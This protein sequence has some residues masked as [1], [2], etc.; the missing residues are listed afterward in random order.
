MTSHEQKFEL[1]QKGLT[2][3]EIARAL[4]ISISAVNTWRRTKGLPLNTVP[5]SA[6][7]N[8]CKLSDEENE[9]RMTL[10]QKGFLDQDIAKKCGVSISTITSWRRG[11]GLKSNAKKKRDYFYDGEPF[12]NSKNLET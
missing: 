12:F 5:W 4:S 10:Y 1:Y 8:H 9:K 11:R 2:D 6:T 7:H 3:V